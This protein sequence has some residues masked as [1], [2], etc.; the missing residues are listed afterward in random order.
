MFESLSD[1][2]SGIFDKLTRRGALT[3]SDVSE[4]MREVRRAL[5]EADVALDVVRDFTDKV[6]EKAVGQE[7][8]KSITPGQMVIKIVH[9]EL[10]AM[11]G[12][13]SQTI[14]FTA[15]PPVPILMVGLQ[16]SGKTTSTAKIAYRLTQRDKKKVLMASL[17]TRRPAAQEQLRV[18]GEQTGVS[19]LPIVA[20]Q[21]PLQIARRAMGPRAGEGGRRGGGRWGEGG[22][23]AGAGGG[24]RGPPPPF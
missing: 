21:T 8:V 11:L 10:V 20:G 17:D 24:E 16:G 5:L 15:L 18:L 9:D 12:S 19:T 14:D 4:A 23:G 22:G 1:R 13:D 3:D 2:L 7:V 6:K